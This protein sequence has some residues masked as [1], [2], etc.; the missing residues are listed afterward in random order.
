MARAYIGAG[1][2]LGDRRRNLDRAVRELRRLG[3]VTGISSVYES[4]P[5]G[6]TEQPDFWNV[7]VRVETTAEPRALLAALKA[8]ESRIGRTP[9]FRNGPR[10]IDLDLL[11]YDDVVR[12]STDI[13]LPHPRWLDRSFVIE[14][15][16]ELDPSLTDP[17]TGAS[18][19]EWRSTMV[20]ARLTRLFGGTELDRRPDPAEAPE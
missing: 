8:A 13:E 19:T 10:A 12:T 14:P 9:T 11:L 4:E 18:I 15:L 16:L 5:I 1:T 20:P 7:V 2:N 6:Y 17:R 3:R